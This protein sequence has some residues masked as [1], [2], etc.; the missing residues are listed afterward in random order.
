MVL[1]G[2]ENA[3]SKAIALLLPTLGTRLAAH[4]AP[5]AFYR[6]E[7]LGFYSSSTAVF[8]LDLGPEPI[9]S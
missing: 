1:T 8:S 9:G 6:L 5:F 3:K 7:E 2:P 4:F